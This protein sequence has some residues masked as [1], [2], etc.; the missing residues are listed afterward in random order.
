[1]YPGPHPSGITTRINW[2]CGAMP[3]TLSRP[4]LLPGTSTFIFMPGHM[5]GGTTTCNGLPST[6]KSRT[7]P[8]PHPA[9]TIHCIWRRFACRLAKA[10]ASA[11]SLLA[12]A[13]ALAFSFFAF[14]SA[15]ALSFF[16]VLA[17]FALS[18]AC[19]SARVFVASNLAI[20]EASR[21]SCSFR[22]R[23]WCEGQ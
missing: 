8:G 2:V 10:S 5:P 3:I 22:W 14:A 19:C 20:S 6:C 18:L 15:L 4:L 23:K 12:S 7:E 9:G 21:A 1:M 16:S 11:L 13:A 17:A